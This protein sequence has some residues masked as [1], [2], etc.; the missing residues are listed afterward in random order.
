M[1]FTIKDLEKLKPC[2]DG[3]KWYKRNIKSDDL[4]EILEQL[5]DHRP[6]WSR[7]LM[8]RVLNKEQNQQ[9]AIYCAELVLPIYE[10]KYPDDLR[11]PLSNYSNVIL[12]QLSWNYVFCFLNINLNYSNSKKKNSAINTILILFLRLNK[13]KNF[14]NIKI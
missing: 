4:K 5:Q 14:I 10:D 6:D 12:S 7:W 2:T 3:Y 8:V 1:K 11:V 13:D 9:L